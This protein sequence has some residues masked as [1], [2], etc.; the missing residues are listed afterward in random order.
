MVLTA[1]YSYIKTLRDIVTRKCEVYVLIIV[2]YL[3][4]WIKNRVF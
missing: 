3:L 1:N 4:K 2:K